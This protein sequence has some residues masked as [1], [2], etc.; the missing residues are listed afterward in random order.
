M[1]LGGSLGPEAT[2]AMGQTRRGHRIRVLDPFGLVQRARAAMRRLRSRPL[3]LIDDASLEKV[4]L[5]S[6]RWDELQR[7]LLGCSTCSAALTI[8]NIAGFSVVDGRYHFFCNAPSCLPL[9]LHE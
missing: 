1:A 3:S 4:L 6:G 8:D 5:D 9:R 2:E 7:G